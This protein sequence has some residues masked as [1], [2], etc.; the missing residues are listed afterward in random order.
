MRGMTSNLP[1]ILLPDRPAF[2]EQRWEGVETVFYGKS[3]PDNLPSVTGV[4]AW[5]ISAELRSQALHLPGLQWALTLTAGVDDWLRELPDGVKLYNAH[6]LHDDAVAQ[7][8][9][10]LILAAARGLPR[11]A[12]AQE[13]SKPGHLWTLQ[14]RQVVVWGYGHIGQKLAGL[15]TPFGAQVTGLRSR[16]T[17]AEIDTALAQADDLV[18]L[19]PLTPQTRQLVNANTLAKLKAGA[20]LYNLGRGPLVDTGALLSGLDHLGGAALDVTDPEPL[21]AGHPLL[22]HPKVLVTPHIASTTDNLKERGAQFAADFVARHQRGE[23]LDNAVETG[24][25][26]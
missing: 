7:H 6:R 19:L 18:L 24:K 3:L 2:R 23:P 26:Y 14:G 12:R 25:G 17:Q 1:V 13:W 4:V 5:G 22:T 16:S 15:L 8:A 10:A 20:W 9:A 11:F 21:P